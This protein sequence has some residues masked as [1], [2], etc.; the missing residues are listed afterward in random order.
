MVQQTHTDGCPAIHFFASQIA[1]TVSSRGPH[2]F[3]SGTSNVNPPDEYSSCRYSRVR[4][5]SISSC[6]R[7]DQ[8]SGYPKGFHIS[9]PDPKY[10][11]SY[12]N[13]MLTS[14]LGV[15]FPSC[16]GRLLQ[17]RPMEGHAFLDGNVAFSSASP[18]YVTSGLSISIE[19][20]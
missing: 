7:R 18:T 3:R 15:N 5:C 1:R 6:D 10:H 19:P 9:N 13:P 16:T 17:P 12:L 2:V 4:T 11:Y 8:F 14:L 20:D